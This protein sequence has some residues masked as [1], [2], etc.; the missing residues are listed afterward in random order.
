MKNRFPEVIFPRFSAEGSFLVNL[1]APIMACLGVISYKVIRYI[2]TRKYFLLIFAQERKSQ[3]Q[4]LE[5]E[6]Y[7]FNRKEHNS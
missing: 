3:R 7:C 6:T 2:V 4:Q 5:T 1:M